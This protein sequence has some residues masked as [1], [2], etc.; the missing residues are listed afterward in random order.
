[1][2]LPKKLRLSRRQRAELQRS[3]A[4][5]EWMQRPGDAADIASARTQLKPSKRRPESIP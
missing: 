5:L 1:M 4:E 2:K 3:I